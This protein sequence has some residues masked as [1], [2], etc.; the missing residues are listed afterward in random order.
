VLVLVAFRVAQGAGAGLM[1][2]QVMSLIQLGFT[3]RDR[4][5]ALS[6]YGVVLA[7]GA[8]VG[9][10]AGGLVAGADLFG[11]SWR[12]A[13]LINVPIGIV[14]LV[15]SRRY[16]P[17]ERLPSSRRLWPLFDV[18]IL[19]IR[20]FRLGLISM[21]AMQAAYGGFMFVYTLHL[22]ASTGA[23]AV[24]TGLT[25]LAIAVPFGVAGYGWRRLPAR[26]WLWL[27]GVGLLVSAPAYM[28]AIGFRPATPAASASL[29][30]LGT[31]LGLTVG[32]LMAQA[33][34]TI[35]T[36]LVGDAS[37]GLTTTV[38]L[39]QA[40]GVAIFGALYASL[41]ASLVLGCLWA[42]CAL[43]AAVA[44]TLGVRGLQRPPLP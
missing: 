29:V 30:V 6:S 21:A 41:S 3:G 14:L 15:L 40:G 38:Q 25:F 13:F 37:A 22:H 43:L 31:G 28:G 2:P 17:G 5:R 42:G 33:L 18:G 20:R 35:P 27:P 34:S 32:P 16:L 19:A 39:A 36:A 44:C 11:L 8:A 4:A 10:L 26:M 23:D 7:A 1:L 24:Q 12:P 9:L